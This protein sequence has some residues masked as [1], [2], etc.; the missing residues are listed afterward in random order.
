MLMMLAVATLQGHSQ[1]KVIYDFE[2]YEIG[3]RLPMNDLYSDKTESVAEV[4]A[5]PTNPQTRSCTSPTRV[6]T[7]LSNLP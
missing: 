6:G 2:G 4:T 5:D 7:P 1:E 3:D